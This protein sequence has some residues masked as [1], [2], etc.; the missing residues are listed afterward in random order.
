[1]MSKFIP[2]HYIETAAG[3]KMLAASLI[4]VMEIVGG[5]GIMTP[6]GQAGLSAEL[7]EEFKTTALNPVILDAAGTLL[8]MI[9]IPWFAELAP[10][11]KVL[12]SIWLRDLVPPRG[13]S[14]PPGW[15]NIVGAPLNSSVTVFTGYD[16]QRASELNA[17]CLQGVRGDEKSA[18]DCMQKWQY[19][20][21]PEM[22]ERMQRVRE[23]LRTTLP[24]VDPDG[25][26]FAG[27]YWSETDYWE[28]D[29]QESYWGAEKYA[30]LVKVKRKY[31]PDDFF[32][33]HH[34]AGSEAWT[35]QS[36]LMCRSNR[37]LACMV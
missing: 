35:A 29:W 25:N 9:Q 34:C 10:S 21:V 19:K 4:Q 30:E 23:M 12:K 7:V 20:L 17:L 27:A 5:A 36:N 1:M 2:L 16:T 37:T 6:K 18:R 14:E 13:P 33:C 28:Q 24:N 8:L 3:R 32:V 22:Q 11:S 31:D 26:L 15:E